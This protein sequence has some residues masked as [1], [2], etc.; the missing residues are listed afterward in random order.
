MI[1]TLLLENFHRSIYIMLMLIL[2]KPTM[3]EFMVKNSRFIAEAV[4]IDSPESAKAFWHAQK[5]RYDNGGH[6][7]YA[8]IT[9]PQGNIMGCSDDGEPSGTAGRPMLAVLKGSGLTNTIIT[10]AR[11]FGGTKLGTGGLVRA[12]SECARAALEWAEMTELVPMESL[13]MIIPYSFYDQAKHLLTNHGFTIKGE[14]FTDSVTLTGEIRAEDIGG[15][16][17]ELQELTGAK[18]R[19]AKK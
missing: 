17:V 12:Y 14:E 16:K 2:K 11:W 1:F 9:G 19:F 7:V 10:A 8:F 6:I 4:P 5:E 13:T 18:C 3:A 15:L